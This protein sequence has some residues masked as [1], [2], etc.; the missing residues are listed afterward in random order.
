MAS[1]DYFM[2]RHAVTTNQ[3]EKDQ[4]EM[5]AGPDFTFD[6]LSHDEMSAVADGME[7]ARPTIGE[8]GD[9]TIDE[10]AATKEQEKDDQLA[11]DKLDAESGEAEMGGVRKEE[12]EEEAGGG[13]SAGGRRAAQHLQQGTVIGSEFTRR[14]A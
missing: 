8:A 2:K 1:R 11:Q 10:M 12:E 4:I 14:R 9:E 6:I 13:M 3:E 7:G 5:I